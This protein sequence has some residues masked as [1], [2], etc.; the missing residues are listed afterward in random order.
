MIWIC[1]RVSTLRMTDWA[2]VS[3]AI[4][5]VWRRNPHALVL[6]IIDQVA[7]ARMD[8]REYSF[9][10]QEHHRPVAG[11]TGHDVF[12][13]NVVDVLLHVSLEGGVTEMRSAPSRN[14]RS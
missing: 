9:G 5:V 14:M 1:L 6:R 11:F 2:V 3:T 4:N 13:R 8:F 12:V 10:G 7:M